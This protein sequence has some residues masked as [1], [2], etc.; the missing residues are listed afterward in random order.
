M[1]EQELLF[2]QNLSVTS[3]VQVASARLHYVEV[4]PSS[5]FRNPTASTFQ[6]LQQNE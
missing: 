4:I 6:V 2:F 1:I 3:L 5:S